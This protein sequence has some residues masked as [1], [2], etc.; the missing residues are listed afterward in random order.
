ME[1][2]LVLQK[3]LARDENR[4]R[5]RRPAPGR[6]C[7]ASPRHSCCDTSVNTDEN[8]R[9]IVPLP[10]ASLALAKPGPGRVLSE[11]VG[12]TLALARREPLFKIGEYEWCEPD[13]RQILLWAGS[14]T[15][16][17]EEV[18]RRL[19][20]PLYPRNGSE[21]REGRIVKLIWDFDLLP[22]QDFTWVQGLEIEQLRFSVHRPLAKDAPRLSLSLPKLYEL[23]CDALGLEELDLSLVPSL[24]DLV[25]DGNRLRSIDL[26]SVPLLECFRCSENHLETLELSK[27]LTYVHCE[28]NNLRSL[29]LSRCEYLT[30]LGCDGNRLREV[31]LQSKWDSREERVGRI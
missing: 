11:M 9:A 21:F 14:L 28:N 23:R 4:F 30:F 19:L 20:N 8:S 22:L 13:Y 29:D 16:E 1:N 7:I 18:I 2:R 26:S 27:G 31:D 3:R 5:L 24:F 10:D 12:D 15:L 17:P 6:K 25:C